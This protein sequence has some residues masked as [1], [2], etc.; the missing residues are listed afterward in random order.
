MKPFLV[1]SKTRVPLKKGEYIDLFLAAGG[2][3]EKYGL[4]YD[5]EEVFKRLI[6]RIGDITV[7]VFS[8]GSMLV[9]SGDLIE[10]D[11]QILGIQRDL[12]EFVFKKWVGWLSQR[13]WGRLGWEPRER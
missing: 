12:Q 8:T 10:N 6:F 4:S 9:K 7:V 3:K 1:I 5:G 13:I 11:R 2:L